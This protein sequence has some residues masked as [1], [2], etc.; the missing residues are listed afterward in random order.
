V[1]VRNLDVSAL[2][3][4]QRYSLAWL[5]TMF[6]KRPIIETAIDRIARASMSDAS[7]V[8]GVYT[9]PEVPFLALMANLRMLRSGGEINDP[10]AIKAMME[11]RGY[12]DVEMSAAPV[13]TFVLGRVQ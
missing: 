1:N 2:E 12:V 10:A 9:R 3:E 7:L 5:P 8:A 4:R 13:A 6:L 11:A